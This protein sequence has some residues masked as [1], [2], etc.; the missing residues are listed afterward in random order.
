MHHHIAQSKAQYLIFRVIH[1]HADLGS[2][3]VVSNQCKD[4]SLAS[5][6]PVTTETLIASNLKGFG[7]LKVSLLDAADVNV[8][9]MQGVFKLCLLIK[10]SFCIPMHNI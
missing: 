3:N 1:V 5:S 8:P 7:F 6:F 4:A 9:F 10:E 2:S